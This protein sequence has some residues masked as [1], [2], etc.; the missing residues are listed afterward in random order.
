MVVPKVY[1]QL[2]KVYSAWRMKM[3]LGMPVDWLEV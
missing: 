1:W 2:F 3:Y